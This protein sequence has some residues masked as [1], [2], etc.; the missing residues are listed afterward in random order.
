LLRISVAIL[1]DILYNVN[2]FEITTNSVL[3]KEGCYCVISTE[4]KRSGHC[5]ICLDSFLITVMVIAIFFILLDPAIGEFYSN[6]F[7]V[8]FSC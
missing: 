1:L 4:I 3:E 8:L 7:W 6:F 2:C 5:R